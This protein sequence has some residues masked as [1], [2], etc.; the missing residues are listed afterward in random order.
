MYAEVLRFIADDR[1]RM[2][3]IIGADL[4]IAENRH[5]ANEPRTRA[6]FDSALEQTERADLD[7]RRQFHIG[8]DDRRGMDARRGVLKVAHLPVVS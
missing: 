7:T 6:D 8:A 1:G 2:N 3:H 5:V 4:G